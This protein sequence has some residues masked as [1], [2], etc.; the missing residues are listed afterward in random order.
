VTSEDAIHRHGP[1]RAT[2][3][4]CLRQTAS[5]AAVRLCPASRETSSSGSPLSERR[6]TKLRRRLALVHEQITQLRTENQ[7]LRDANETVLADHDQL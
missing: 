6:D 2:G 1:D 4:I 7:H 3:R 5:V